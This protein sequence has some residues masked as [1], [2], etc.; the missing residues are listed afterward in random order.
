M[1]SLLFDSISLHCFI[2]FKYITHVI[3]QVIKTKN[4]KYGNMLPNNNTVDYIT[5][6]HKNLF[7]LEDNLVDCKYI[8][9]KL[10]NII[11][12]VIRYKTLMQ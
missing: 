8:L 3:L 6:S 4:K 5:I 2:H 1:L 9:R 12:S 7:N 11:K 10:I